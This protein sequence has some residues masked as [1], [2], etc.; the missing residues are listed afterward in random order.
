MRYQSFVTV[1]GYTLLSRL[2]GFLRDLAIARLFGAD[3]NVDAF[4]IAFKLP[5]LL[6]RLFT[7]GAF[8][9]ALVP[10]F[11][12]Y[13]QQHNAE[14]FK[15]FI[16]KF[17]AAILTFL[18]PITLLSIIVAPI[19]VAILAPGFI[20]DPQRFWLTVRILQICLPYVPLITLTA[21][22]VALL[23]SQQRFGLGA[24]I[25]VLLNWCLIVAALWSNGYSGADGIMILS[26]GVLIAGIIQ[27]FVTLP[28]LYQLNLLSKP[29]FNDNELSWYR[30]WQIMGPALI[31][32]SVTQLNL[33]LDTLLVSFLPVGSVAWLYYANRLMEFPQGI[34]GAALSTV[35]LPHL[36]ACNVN[37]DMVQF[38]KTLDQSLRLVLIIGMPAA[39]GLWILAKPII[40]TLFQSERFT[41]QDV[42]MTAISLQ[43]YACGLP[44]YLLVK[45]LI[46]GY[47]ARQ[48][49]RIPVQIAA[50]ATGLNIA[51]SIILL[52]PLAHLGLAWSSSIATTINAGWLWYELINKKVYEFTPGWYALVLRVV[53]ACLI[54][55]F[56]LQ[57]ISFVSS[58]LL[59]LTLTI[60]SGSMIYWVLLV[61]LGFQIRHVQN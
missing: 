51:L 60:V 31:G 17:I 3:S 23:N 49:N 29:Q 16:G 26:W 34:V 8:A 42:N 44:A 22:A 56:F 6:R 21:C 24:F 46:P 14:E 27:L 58:Q 55:G 9:L 28:F 10:V 33:L 39:V 25:P 40:A 19:L 37:K 61:L 36:S 45:V 32:T 11:S 54:M 43:A 48:D 18:V 5:N 2:F 30:L 41:L 57:H 50:I 52:W 38:S 35:I 12:Q 20:T 1:S 13:Q 15:H 7:E 59:N 47:Y 53:I 4:L